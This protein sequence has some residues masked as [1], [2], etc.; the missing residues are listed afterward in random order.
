MSH[1]YGEIQGSRGEA[2]RCGTEDSGMYGHIRGWGVG[3]SVTME[4]QDGKDVAVVRKT[5]GSNGYSAEVIF[6]AYE[7]GT[8]KYADDRL[9]LLNKTNTIVD[10]HER[11]Q[12]FEDDLRA[13]GLIQ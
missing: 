10:K 5:G 9:N 1:F 6:Y 11:D 3:V 8:I 7:D 2:T 13:D 4:R 12:E